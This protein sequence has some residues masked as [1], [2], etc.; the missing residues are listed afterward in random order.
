MNKLFLIASLAILITGCGLS[1]PTSL[2]LH[3]STATIKARQADQT[4]TPITIKDLTS[5]FENTAKRGKLVTFEASFDREQWSI[6][7]GSNHNG[8]R[9]WDRDGNK[10][11]V[12]NIY[13]EHISGYPTSDFR[14]FNPQARKNL[15][16]YGRYVKIEG[17]YIPG[18]FKTSH[19]GAFFL[20]PSINVFTIDGIPV[21]E[22]VKK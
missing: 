5:R 8:Y 2:T 1:Q 3:Q 4:F 6:A 12:Y 16:N 17:E 20:D 15:L 22:Y 10:I 18:E 19:G 7:Y 11:R 21:E 13:E 9:L 14:D